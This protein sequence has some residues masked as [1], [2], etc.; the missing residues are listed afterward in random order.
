M[1]PLE[2][3]AEALRAIE[4]RRATGKIVLRVRA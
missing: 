2:Q 1:F 4:E 3:G